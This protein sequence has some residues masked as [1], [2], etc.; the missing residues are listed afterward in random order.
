M[1]ADVLTWIALG[2][3]VLGALLSSLQHALS[4]VSRP[5]LETLAARRTIAKTNGNLSPQP[6]SGG[7]PGSSDLPGLVPDRVGAILE[8]LEGHVAAIAVPRLVCNLLAGVA[9]VLAVAALRSDGQPGI[10]DIVLGLS[11]AVIGLWTLS[12]ALPLAIARHAAEHT[13]YAWSTLLR[14]FHVVLTPLRRVLDFISEVVRRLAG[15]EAVSEVE[16]RE[17]ELLSLVEESEREG[18]LDETAREMIEAVVEFRS[19]T[20]EQIMTPRTEVQAF[21]YTDDLEKVKAM[22]SDVGHS[23]VPVYTDDLDHIEGLLYLKDLLRYLA[24]H[25]AQPSGFNLKD[26]LR[27]ATYVPETKTIRELLTE[28]LDEKVHIAIALDEY[29]GTSG[30]VTIEDI[31][32][33]V[34]GEIRDEYEPESDEDEQ[35]ILSTTD[36]SAEI[37]GRAEIDAANDDLEPIGLSIPE[38]E[39]YDTVAGFVVT[40]LGRIP[41]AGE[42]FRENGLVV[43]VLDAEPTRVKRIR[44]EHAAGEEAG[45]PVS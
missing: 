24:T 35:V 20:V 42:S 37:E 17:A 33:E 27:E 22:V 9:A 4:E 26:V 41:E 13:V 1:S 2:C 7:D 29:G 31:V 40:T 32:E 36:R 34:F 11:A 3:A 39:D 19:T 43:T 30:I 8:D 45:E 14:L 44:V 18:Q 21:E 23:R 38:G 16:A 10:L 25:P 5:A 6:A 15:L 12:V 28:L